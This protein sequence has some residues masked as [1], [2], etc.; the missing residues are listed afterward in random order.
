MHDLLKRLEMRVARL[1]KRAGRGVPMSKILRYADTGVFIVSAYRG[2]L[3]LRENKLRAEELRRTL[4][5]LA[6]GDNRVIRLKS[7]YEE[8]GIG[9]VK[10]QSFL[11]LKSLPFKV[12][13]RI[14]RS[15]NQDSFIWS[16]PNFPLT[17][18]DSVYNTATVALNR[19]MKNE[20]DLEETFSRGTGGTGFSIGFNWDNPIPWMGNSPLSL[21]DVKE[22]WLGVA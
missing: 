8:A 3:S 12:C 18:Y 17:M 5:K 2:N 4:S 19:E 11:V 10:E 7:Q 15:Y 16:A 22:A 6:G 13:L 20:I 21:E 14:S 9:L 1:E